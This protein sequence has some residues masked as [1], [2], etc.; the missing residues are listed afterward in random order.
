MYWGHRLFQNVCQALHVPGDWH[1]RGVAYAS[2][3]SR[4]AIALEAVR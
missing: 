3:S 1:C 4:A 2:S